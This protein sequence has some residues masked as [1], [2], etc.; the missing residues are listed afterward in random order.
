MVTQTLYEQARFAALR[1]AY[2][3]AFR[4]LSKTVRQ[5]Q[6]VAAV[7]DSDNQVIEEARR[8]MEQAR[9]AYHESRDTLA[10]FL[11]SRNVDV[12]A[13]AGHPMQTTTA[14]IGTE[15]HDAES[16]P[17]L[18]SRIE[19]LAHQLWE[20]SGRPSGRAEEHWYLA[21]KLIHSAL[22]A[23]KPGSPT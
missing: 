2:Y 12:F 5:L 1:E 18:R 9:L 17:D 16:E 19:Y 4:E 13:G 21:E 7:S 3:Q 10:Q 22:A 11:L 6:S 20:Q 15:Q 8:N 14:D 23:D